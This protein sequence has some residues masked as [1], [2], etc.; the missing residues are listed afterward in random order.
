M[1]FKEVARGLGIS[2]P[3]IQDWV[4]KD[5]KIPE[6]RLVQ[7]STFYYARKLIFKM[8][9]FSQKWRSTITLFKHISQEM[10]SCF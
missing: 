10:S 3:T 7:L 9:L 6:K 4:N 8:N 5:R 1:E 2:P